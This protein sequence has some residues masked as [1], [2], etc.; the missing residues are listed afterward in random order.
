MATK[1]FLRIFTELSVI[2]YR[3]MKCITL[4][5]HKQKSCSF[6]T[7][8]LNE[9]LSINLTET[10]VNHSSKSYYG[11]S[12]VLWDLH[13]SSKTC[14]YNAGTHEHTHTAHINQ[15][16]YWFPP[17]FYFLEGDNENPYRTSAVGRI[18]V[19]TTCSCGIYMN[20]I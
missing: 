10:R 13:Y 17:C 4:G 3:N 15:H 6:A 2:R 7:L 5:S 11:Q 1:R 18:T 19:K 20:E 14:H 9:L 16:G 12:Q 8:Y